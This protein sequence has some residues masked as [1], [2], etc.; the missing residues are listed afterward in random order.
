MKKVEKKNKKDV[1]L[2]FLL[3]G[4]LPPSLLPESLG[5]GIVVNLQ[6]GDLEIKG[7]SISCLFVIIFCYL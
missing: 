5:K 6:L 3:F 2:N 7:I 4:T 1:K